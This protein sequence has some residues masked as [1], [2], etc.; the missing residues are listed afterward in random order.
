MTPKRAARPE[1]PRSAD[2]AHDRPNCPDKKKREAIFA[3]GG[4][5]AP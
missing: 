4:E 3:S 5:K 1:P 2:K